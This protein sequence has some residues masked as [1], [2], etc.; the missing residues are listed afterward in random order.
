MPTDPGSE[1]GH[2]TQ[3]ADD[4]DPRLIELSREYLEALRAGENPFQEDYLSRVPDLGEDARDYL[5]GI[6][7]A[8]SLEKSPEKSNPSPDEKQQ[9]QDPFIGEPIGDFRIVKEIGR[10]GMG[11]VY[12]AVQ[13]SLGR[14]VALKVLPFAAALDER[15]RKRFLLEAQ[16][17]AQL[18]HN[19]I[20]PVYAVGC[21]R[22]T[23]YYAMQLINGQPISN[24]LFVTPSRGSTSGGR[25]G[26]KDTLPWGSTTLPNRSMQASSATPGWTR[27]QRIASLIADAAEGLEY[28]HT[29]GVVHRDVK[30]AN[31]LLDTHGKIW[32]AD[33]GLAQITS[34]EHVTQTGDMLGTMRYMSPEQA[35]G[36]RGVVD[37]RSDV[38]SLGATLYELLTGKPVFDGQDRQTL[39]S[40]VLNDDP[41][42]LRQIEKSTPEELEIITLKALRH[43]PSDRYETAQHF[44]DDLR[45]FLSEMPIAARRP[46]LIDKTRKWARRHPTAVLSAL[47]AMLVMMISLAVTAGV[48]THQKSLTQASLSREKIRAA[49]AEKRLATAQAAADEMIQMAQNEFTNSPMEETLR[50]R[51]LSAALTYYEA[52]LDDED[53]KTDVRAELSNTYQNVAAIQDELLLLREARQ[54]SLLRDGAVRA[55]LQLTDEQTLSLLQSSAFQSFLPSSNPMEDARKR[56]EQI[57][58]VLTSGQRNRLAQIALQLQGPSAI[59]ET[60]LSGKL[61]LTDEQAAGVQTTFLDY[62]I[63]NAHARPTDVPVNDWEKTSSFRPDEW[64]DA[65]MKQELLKLVLERLTPEQRQIWSQI[66]GPKF[67]SS[68][69][70]DTPNNE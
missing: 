62:L 69:K 11:I 48:V 56:R 36:T 66:T 51:L 30:P 47:F 61:D 16:A 41:K 46:T 22:G 45:R 59:I 1:T 23:H 12:E 31:L 44:A 24:D 68:T 7:L 37:H 65:E 57:E 4:I 70:P 34:G 14:S 64:L 26:T 25:E 10:G 9:Q 43:S 50:L 39:L 21:E 28:A 20:V 17:A 29:C 2:Q 5:E 60:M 58:K 27:F 33:F 32:I 52:L 53:L 38:Y 54:F 49:Q 3:P 19:H 67:E 18:H 6:E 15:H 8:F 13:I 55:D 63:S 42:P 35:S 40:Q